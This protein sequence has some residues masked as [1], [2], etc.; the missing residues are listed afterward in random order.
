MI[1][2]KANEKKA[3]NTRILSANGSETYLGELFGYIFLP[4]DHRKRR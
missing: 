1:P 4:N 3:D 2:M